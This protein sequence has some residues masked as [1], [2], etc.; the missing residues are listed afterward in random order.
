MTTYLISTSGHRDGTLCVRIEA[1]DGRGMLAEMEAITISHA[2]R[3][4]SDLA[5]LARKRDPSAAIVLDSSVRRA[6]GH[7]A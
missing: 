6:A 7:Y 3:I 5:L 4:G 1:D 2:G